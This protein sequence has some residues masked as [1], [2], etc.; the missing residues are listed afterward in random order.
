[1]KKIL[2]LLAGFMCLLLLLAPFVKDQFQEQPKVSETK[3][4]NKKKL[5]PD[6]SSSPAPPL[7]PKQKITAATIGAVGD[8][9]IHDR[10]YNTVRK[11]NGSYDFNPMFRF[12]KPY[13]EKTDIMVANQETMIGGTEIGVSGFPSFNSP[14]EVGDALKANGVDLVTIANNH[15]LDRGEKAILNALNH[16]N[17]IGMPYTGAYQS[18]EDQQIIRILKRNDITFSFLSYTYGTNG[19]SVPAGK[20]HLV[21]LIDTTRIQAEVKEAEKISD[22][23]VISL[24]FG[25][26]YERLPND[27]QKLLAQTTANAGA[28]IIIGHHPHVLQPVSWLSKP[29]GERA[30]V[31]YSLGNFLSGQLRDYTNIGGIMQIGVKKIQTGDDVK[32]ELQNPKF[33]PT[34]VNRPFEIIPMKA[35]SDQAAKYNEIQKHMNQFMPELSFD[36]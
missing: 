16:W 25:K 12:V 19:I 26:E 9:L 35:S 15:T 17:S 32:I 31:A 6:N 8:I 14:V 24:H 27:A 29:N 13:L 2:V 34:W 7:V 23:V 18:S 10:V 33:L 36:F 28:D 1:M 20:P 11:S 5:K 3:A 4:E 22:V 30:F 21:N